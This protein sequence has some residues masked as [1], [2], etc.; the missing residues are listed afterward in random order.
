[1]VFKYGTRNA[2]VFSLIMVFTYTYTEYNFKQF[3]F[4]QLLLQ[5]KDIEV[6]ALFCSIPPPAWPWCGFGR[7]KLMSEMEGFLSFVWLKAGCIQ[8]SGQ[9]GRS[10]P[11]LLPVAPFPIPLS[12]GRC[13]KRRCWQA[14]DV[15]RKRKEKEQQCHRASSAKPR[16]GGLHRCHHWNNRALLSTSTKSGPGKDSPNLFQTHVMSQLVLSL[17][18]HCFQA[19]WGGK[20]SFEAPWHTGFLFP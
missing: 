18:F 5:R 14:Q 10:S 8:P 20:L 13:W 2:I 11:F 12:W 19:G 16:G 6:L 9:L 7:R 4:I 17:F 15:L 1:M 3:F